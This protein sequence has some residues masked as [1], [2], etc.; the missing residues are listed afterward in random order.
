MLDYQT[1]LKYAVKVNEICQDADPFDFEPEM[2]PAEEIA[3]M[4]INK[5]DVV[6]TDLS[7]I[8]ENALASDDLDFYR[9]VKN[10]LDHI[11]V[12]YNM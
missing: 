10:V 5:D 4:I 7:E 8:M 2:C 12:F 1:I 3:A 9:K 6:L 11:K